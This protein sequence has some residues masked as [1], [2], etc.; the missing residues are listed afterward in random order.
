MSKNTIL[1]F[2]RS[3]KTYLLA[4]QSIDINS[5]LRIVKSSAVFFQQHPKYS[6]FQVRYDAVLF[7]DK[8]FI[9]QHLKD[10]W[11]VL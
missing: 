10:A 8:S 7:K 5:Q 11:R 1:S 4:A 3:K 9:P 2:L 6:S